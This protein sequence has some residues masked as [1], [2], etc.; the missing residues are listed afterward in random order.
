MKHDI[1]EFDTHII[2]AQVRE[3]TTGLFSDEE[4]A[5]GKASAAS[6]STF[7]AH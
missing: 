2:Y 5:K 4:K 6:E 3:H 7:S 1:E